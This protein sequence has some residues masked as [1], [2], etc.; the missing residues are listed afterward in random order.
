[1][2]AG[3]SAIKIKDGSRTTRPRT[4]CDRLHVMV[5]GKGVGESR[6]ASPKLSW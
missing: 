4:W 2:T 1:M 6:F 3:D 5:Q